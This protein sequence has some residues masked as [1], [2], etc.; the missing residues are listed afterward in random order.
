MASS[1]LNVAVLDDY[2]GFSESFFA[3]LDPASFKSTVWHRSRSFASCASEP[4]PRSPHQPPPQPPTPPLHQH[5]QQLPPPPRPRR[6]RHPAAGTF[7]K[8]R[9]QTASN[10]APDSTTTHCIALIL[11]LVRDIPN[12]HA[13]IQSGQWQVSMATALPGKVFGVLGL[14]R[15]GL[16]VA[17]IMSTL[18]GRV[19]AAGLPVDSPYF[20]GEKTVRVVTKEE[21]FREAD[22]V[23][24]HLVLSDRTRGVVAAEDLARMKP[25]AF[26]V[27][28]SRGP[29]V[30]ERDLLDT[31]KEGT[32]AGAAID[33]FDMEPLPEDSE[34]RTVRWG[35]GGTSRVVLTPHMGYMAK[36]TMTTWYEQQVENIKRWVAGEELN[37]RDYER[38]SH[39]EKGVTTRLLMWPEVPIAALVVFQLL[40]RDESND[41]VQRAKV[42]S[43]KTLLRGF[44]VERGDQRLPA[45]PIPLL[46]RPAPEIRCIIYDYMWSS[47]GFQNGIHIDV[48]RPQGSSSSAAAEGT[49]EPLSYP[50]LLEAD[51]AFRDEAVNAEIDALWD[52][53]E[54][55]ASS[56]T[57][58]SSGKGPLDCWFDYSRKSKAARERQLEAGESRDVSPT[59]QPLLPVLLTCKRLYLEAMPSFFSDVPFIFQVDEPHAIHS[60]LS[61][62]PHPSLPHLQTVHVYSE[63]TNPN[64]AHGTDTEPIPGTGFHRALTRCAWESLARLPALRRIRYHQ[65]YVPPG[66]DIDLR[67][68]TKMAGAALASKMT[69]EIPTVHDGEDGGTSPAAVE[70]EGETP[71][72][73]KRRSG[74]E[75]APPFGE[76]QRFETLRYWQEDEDL[77][78]ETKNYLRKVDDDLCWYCRN[79]LV[80]FGG[81]FWEG[82]IE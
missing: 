51:D 27:N 35:T 81:E 20:P 80:P 58:E 76:V 39:A 34:W 53:H 30:K 13:A 1:V 31:L 56:A 38:L 15:L 36:E 24:V 48:R 16:N 2:Q 32:I 71:L 37:T 62:N 17:R 47:G 12:S 18:F 59:W 14:G 49:Y 77:W 21:L 78:P 66:C 74:L 22:I 69:L 55:R 5:P 6:P 3:T 50:C 61:H 63:T 68:V 46:P 10:P 60:F 25:T 4:L 65:S 43:L 23:S 29:L 7:E 44:G 45:S 40:I 28:T 8:N 70:E 9:T 64:D 82:G 79:R 54:A 52:D 42:K 73:G 72:A 19:A 41:S 11:A 75:D 57:E 33:V 26:L 67:N